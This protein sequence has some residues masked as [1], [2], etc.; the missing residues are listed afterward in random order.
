MVKTAAV[1]SENQATVMERVQNFPSTAEEKWQK[2][3][4]TGM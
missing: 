3:Q 2:L 1:N 4:Q